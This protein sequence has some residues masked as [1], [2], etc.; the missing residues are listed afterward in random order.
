VPAQIASL[1][2]LI[3]ELFDGVP[4]D[5]MTDAEHAVHE[6]A[7]NIAADV[8]ARLNTADT[9][10]DADRKTIIDTARVALAGFQPIP[11]EV[12]AQPVKTP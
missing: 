8:C 12:A 5:R 7:A 10:S 9:L 3:A 6:A 4:L 1:L 2:A 11:A